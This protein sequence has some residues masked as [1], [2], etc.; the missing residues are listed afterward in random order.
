M[1][2]TVTIMEDKNEYHMQLNKV[3]VL[4]DKSNYDVCHIVESLT[5]NSKRDT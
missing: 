3:K 1:S 5:L 4:E 2:V